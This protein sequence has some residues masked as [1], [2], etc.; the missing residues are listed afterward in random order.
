[1]M[2]VN[3]FAFVTGLHLALLQFGYLFVLQ[4]NVS[5]TYLTYAMVVIAWMTG[6]LI[7]ISWKT[8]NNTG[9]LAAGVVSYYAVY[10]LVQADPFSYRILPAAVAGVVVTGLWAGRFFIAM[11]PLFPRV[12]SLFLH[13]NNGF[14]VGIV[15]FYLGFVFLG[16]AF[17]LGSIL[18][19]G[20]LLAVH[21]GW[22]TRRYREELVADQ[23]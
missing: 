3:L 9:V 10:A 17:L 11:R 18:V 19:S 7:G 1:M 13:E 21:L 5:S 4:L 6:T 22:L 20:T 15:T 2:N 8:L 16:R 12:N 23:Y 14:L